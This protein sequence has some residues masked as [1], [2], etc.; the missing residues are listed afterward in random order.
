MKVLVTDAI[1]LEGLE[2]LQN[3]PGIE[4]CYELHPSPEKLEKFLSGTGAWLVRS[5]TKVTK[6]WIEKAPDLRLIGRAGV[7]VD[8]IDVQ[9]ATLK[10]IAVVNAPSANTIAACE[11]TFGLMLALS[12]NIAQAD[13]DVKGGRWQRAKWMGTELQG[14][15]LG[16][17][18]LGR[19][20]REVAKRALAF[21]MPVLA[22]D[23]FISAE[24]ARELGVELSDLRTLLGESDFVTLHAPASEKT[25]RL[26]NA[27]TL[28]WM[29]KGGRLI[30]C[31]RGEL[32]DEAALVQALSSGRLGG[33]AL[34]V[35][36][37]EP[38][39]PKSPL[40]QFP[41]VILTPHLG[42]STQEAQSKVAAELSQS[43]ISFYE[44]GIAFN[45]LN[46][47][48]FDAETLKSLG[49][50]LDLAEI[51]GRFLGQMIDSGLRELDCNLQGEFKPSQR[52]P[53]SVAALKG[54][55]STMLAQGVTYVSAPVLANERGIKTSDS[56]DPAARQ[57][58]RQLITLTAVTD[59]GPVSVS[60]AL[61][62]QGEPRIVRLGDLSVEVRPRGKMIVL[63]NRD[64]P[65]MIG[66]VG[67][68]LGQSGIN[69]S[70]M[71]VGRHA[72][73][74]QAVMVLTVDEE[75]DLALRRK[76]EKIEGITSVRW[77]KL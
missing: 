70:D 50:L 68:L 39:D 43:V 13:A 71:R 36:E 5:E 51:M 29:K 48:G 1:D 12:R 69:I 18:G 37:G 31:A 23:P 11:H 19:I 34:D 21:G 26:M 44:K 8:N 56:A 35:F 40:R 59:K 73:H 53:L 67:G 60:G 20:G 64:T 15:T 62:S 58:Y 42:A 3:H 54:L 55:L 45:A 75:A 33:A 30:N 61:M 63:T 17:V 57:G 2:S 76:L 24:Q 77:V 7:G 74:G 49:E 65:G 4:L 32:I 10:G 6:A 16:I 66:K 52:R 9:A 22:L 41:Q 28:S 38:L 27:E 47:P 14:K 46:L 72:P 25:R